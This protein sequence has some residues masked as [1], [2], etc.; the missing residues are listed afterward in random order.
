MVVAAAGHSSIHQF[1]SPSDRPTTGRRRRRK[2]KSSSASF[3]T[4]EICPGPTFFL[5]FAQN[6]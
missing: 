5:L 4:D 1:D 2:E 3:V 6:L